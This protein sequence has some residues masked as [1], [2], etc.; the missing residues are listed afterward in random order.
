MQLADQLKRL[1]RYGYG[2]AFLFIAIMA[3]VALWSAPLLAASLGVTGY[4]ISDAL[5]KAGKG[6]NLRPVVLVAAGVG[7]VS[8]VIF[9]AILGLALD[10]QDSETLAE[11][12]NAYLELAK[13]FGLMAASS[14]LVLSILG[15]LAIVR[16]HSV[17]RQNRT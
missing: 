15:L 7:L 12:G 16:A 6:F 17:I 10:F 13:T 5:V 14:G 9:Y 8:F 2:F 4:L 11:Q 1:L 3:M